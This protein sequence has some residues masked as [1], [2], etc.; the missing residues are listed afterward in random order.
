M[1]ESKI[2]TS[3]KVCRHCGRIIVPIRPTRT[4]SGWR[5]FMS[6]PLKVSDGPDVC[7]GQRMHQP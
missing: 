6:R 4:G 2:P 5:R 3:A 1:S 7:V